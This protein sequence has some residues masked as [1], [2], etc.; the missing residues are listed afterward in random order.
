MKRKYLR[1]NKNTGRDIYSFETTATDTSL[2]KNIFRA[3]SEI[4]LNKI[5]SNAGFE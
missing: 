3:I 5:M 2:V 1:M 4:I